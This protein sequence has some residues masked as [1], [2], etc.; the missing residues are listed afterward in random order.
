MD[1]SRTAHV[2]RRRGVGLLAAALVALLVDAAPAVA[3]DLG[4]A[5]PRGDM[6]RLV[7]WEDPDAAYEPVPGR[8]YGDLARLRLRHTDRHVIVR[9]RFVA[10]RR[11]DPSSDAWDLGVA[12]QDEDGVRRQLAVAV[13][14][15]RSRRAVVQLFGPHR[16]LTC[17]TRQRVDYRADAV[18]VRIPRSCLREPRSLR[19]RA[20]MFMWGYDADDAQEVTFRDALDGPAVS[21]RGWTARIHRG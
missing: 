4:V 11:G 2:R 1:T 14:A 18:R 12:L 15:Y 17:R 10:L 9:A 8:R 13:S 7:D 20:G 5:D 21:A 16:E 19:F 6:E 3:E